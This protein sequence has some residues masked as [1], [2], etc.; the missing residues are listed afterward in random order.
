MPETRYA[1]R[2]E[3]SIVHQS[4]GS[5]PPD[6]LFVPGFVSNVE[7]MWDVPWINRALERL[8]SLGARLFFDKRGTGRPTAPGDPAPP[9]NAWMTC[10]LSLTP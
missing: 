7:L 4:A 5:G 6:I 1:E 8:M 3:L 9:R 10:G 2:G